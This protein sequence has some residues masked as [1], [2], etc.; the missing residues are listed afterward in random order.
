MLR[1]GSYRELRLGGFGRAER[2]S[3]ASGLQDGFRR[4]QRMLDLWGINRASAFSAPFL[5]GGCARGPRRLSGLV[6][7]VHL[8]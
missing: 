4:Y 5:E 2:D 7:L 6:R 8:L 1:N 3:F